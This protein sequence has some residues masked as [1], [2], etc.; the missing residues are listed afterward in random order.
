MFKSKD[1]NYKSKMST[2]TQHP[3]WE[4]EN[5]LT[6]P[7]DRDVNNRW[8]PEQGA[9]VLTEQEVNN[10]IVELNNTSFI[11][12][13]PRVDRTY[14]DPPIPMQ[15]IALI[16]FTPAKG[17][18]PNE[19]GVFGFA[20]IRGNYSSPMEADQRAEY[21]IRNVDSY[22]Q[23]YHAYVGRPFPITF[24]SDYSAETSEIDIRK[25]TTKAVSSNIKT[26][27]EADQKT[28][29]DMREREEILVAESTRAREDDGEGEPVV[30]QYEEYI[31]QCVKKAQLSW[32]FLEHLKKLN[33]VRDIIIK[34]R[35]TLKKMDAVNPDFQTKYFDKYMDA[36]K[37][38]GLDEKLRETQDN[39]I[40][41]MVEEVD[42]PTIDTDEVL[43]AI[44][45]SNKKRPKVQR[46]LDEI[47]ENLDEKE[48]DNDIAPE[49]TID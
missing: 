47:P 33:E 11:K 48:N 9:H 19:N 13:F 28:A 25:E 14:A 44:P 46:V 41:Y 32:T 16:S 18:R 35:E 45:T 26:Q 6:S 10:A 40:K 37:K 8:R 20:K 7:T 22:H 49:E 2:Q 42:L 29:S 27:K 1:V 30:D 21:I 3:D 23:I 17:A 39:F 36:R 5:S 31:T 12:K 38:A 43:P 24:S 15:N 4:K 34:T